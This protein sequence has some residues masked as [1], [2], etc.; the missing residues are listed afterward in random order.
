MAKILF[1]IGVVIICVGVIG[2][3]YHGTQFAK[4]MSKLDKM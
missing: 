2:V 4:E 3:F 1:I